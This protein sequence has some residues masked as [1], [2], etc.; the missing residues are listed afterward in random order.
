MQDRH[1]ELPDALHARRV[2]GRQEPGHHAR[3]LAADVRGHPER[4]LRPQLRP[5]ALRLAADGLR[6]SRCASSRDRIF[7][8]HAKD[9]RLDRERLDDVGILATPLEFHPPKLPG[10]GDVD[11]GRFLSVLAD[12]GY[13]GPVC[14]EV[15]D[16][17]YEGSL[18]ARQSALRQSLRYLRNFA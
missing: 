11:W 14:I 7:H 1:R 16:R 15:E 8:V 18:D 3:D 9:A 6:S 5:V 17:A 13:D 12:T 4:E 10:L 2:A